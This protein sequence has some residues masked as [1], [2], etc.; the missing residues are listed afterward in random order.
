MSE[1]Y[2]WEG[3]AHLSNQFHP[4]HRAAR[5]FGTGQTGVDKL[6]SGGLETT[7]PW[8]KAGRQKKT[9]LLLPGEQEAVSEEIRRTPPVLRDIDPR[10]LHS[11]Q[12]SIVQHHLN[13]YMGTRYDVTGETSADTDNPGNRFPIILHRPGRGQNVILS[14]HHRATAALLKGRPLRALY[15]EG[16]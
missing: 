15:V 2:D 7:T 11:T 6:F 13:H 16:Q 9:G 1:E 14:G 3:I 10:A 5:L 4:Y 12:P 8:Q